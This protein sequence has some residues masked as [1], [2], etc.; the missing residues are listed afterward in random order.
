MRNFVQTTSFA[1]GLGKLIAHHLVF[2]FTYS[3]QRFWVNFASRGTAKCRFFRRPHESTADNQGTGRC[4]LI[5]HC[6]DSCR[7]SYSYFESFQ[8]IETYYNN[9]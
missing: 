8:V 1:G 9:P 3:Q 5:I 2:C 6:I 7:N 4:C